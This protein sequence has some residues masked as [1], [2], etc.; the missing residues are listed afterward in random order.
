MV[1][2]SSGFENHVV[3]HS[4]GLFKR[5]FFEMPCFHRLTILRRGLLHRLCFSLCMYVRAVMSFADKSIMDEKMND[6]NTHHEMS[7]DVSGHEAI[8]ERKMSV[9]NPRLAAVIQENKPNP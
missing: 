3:R 6:S 4:R 8:A 2:E 9:L 1:K 5:T 7:K